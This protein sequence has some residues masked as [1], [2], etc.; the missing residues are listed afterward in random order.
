MCIF[1]PFLNDTAVLD[2][3]CIL[4]QIR[5]GRVAQL[6]PAQNVAPTK[7]NYIHCPLYPIVYFFLYIIHFCYL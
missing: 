6:M 3:S 4:K 5:G 7:P 2:C 1:T